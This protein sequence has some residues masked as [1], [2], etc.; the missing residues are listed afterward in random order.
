M[1]LS[2]TGYIVVINV[3]LNYCEIPTLYVEKGLGRLQFAIA[4]AHLALVLAQVAHHGGID[5]EAAIGTHVESAHQILDLLQQHAILVPGGL[6][7]LRMLH[8]AVKEGGLS[9]PDRLIHRRN[10]D[11]GATLDG[12]VVGRAIVANRGRAIGKANLAVVPTLVRF[13]NGGQIHGGASKF[14]MVLD[15]VQ[16]AIE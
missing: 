1:A 7:V 11:E 16:S 5:A 10:A 14:R 6:R 13:P 2:E 15:Q 8:H 12:Q 3:F 9:L 4:V